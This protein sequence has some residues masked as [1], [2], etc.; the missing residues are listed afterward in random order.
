MN[1][2]NTKESQGI[3]ATAA[4][5]GA[6]LIGLLQVLF[7]FPFTFLFPEAGRGWA[8]SGDAAQHAIAQAYFIRDSWHWPPLLALNLN[9]PEGTNIAFADG[10]P[11]LA[12]PLKLAAPLLPAGFHGIG[13]WYAIATLGQALAAV[14][15]LR[16]AG[17]RR[18][19]PAIGVVLAALAM[20][21]FLA[22]YGH[23]ALTGHAVILLALGVSLRLVRDA[24]RRLWIVT[25][26][27]LVASLLVHPYLAAMAS[28]LIAAAPLTLLL[29]GDRRWAGAA[30]GVVASV[31]AV[32]VTMGAFGYLGAT[33]DGGY[34][35]FAL[36]LLS[37]VWPYRSALFGGGIAREI[38]ATGH[39]GWEGY[40][41]LGAGLIGGLVLAAVL[42][43]AALVALVRRHGGLALALAGL[44][45]LA[46]SHRVGLGERIVLD[47]G[48][49]PGVL[50]QFRASGRFFWPVAYALLIGAAVL[51]ARSG[52]A[53]P[54]LVLAFGI[55]QAVDAAPIRRDLADWANARPAW[56]LDAPALRPMMMQ[57]RALTLLPSWP[58][59]P[60]DATA[61]FVAAHEALALG[62]ERALP[63][64]T[65]HL[66]RWRTPPRCDDAARAAAPLAPGELRLILPASVPALVPLVPDA[67][68]RCGAVGAA[69][70]CR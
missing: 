3:P 8:P 35:Q 4:Y 24:S 1:R 43:P 27:F 64:S 16:S 69:V 42:R 56:T 55:V 21:A 34:G 47:L 51:L 44:T 10:I 53:G 22:R 29:R 48:T 32:A 33:G 15:A 26:A 52:R 68:I 40:N 12:L 31:A 49:V 41:W 45:V 63:A 61:T 66:A 7:I 60:A 5:L 65:M 14:F 54:V 58:C 23:A 30:L 67:A 19:L 36:N 39:G 9:T 62:A 38:D 25:G 17:E 59:I 37:P 28:A 70:A 18:L 50:E 46:I 57:A 11:L 13:L 2:R 6:G 20:P